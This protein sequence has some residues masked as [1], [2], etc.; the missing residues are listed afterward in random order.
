MIKSMSATV[1]LSNHEEIHLLIE[2]SEIIIERRNDY[3]M[4]VGDMILSVVS[5]SSDEIP[6]PIILTVADAIN[7]DTQLA[8]ELIEYIYDMVQ[9]TL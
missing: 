2:N 4:H 8:M 1:E 9:I 6:L 3:G 7:L 5:F